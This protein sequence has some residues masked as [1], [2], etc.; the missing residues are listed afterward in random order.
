M[1]TNNSTQLTGTVTTS[2]TNNTITGSGT[3]FTTQM[4]PGTA[5]GI[6]NDS[7]IVV[8]VNSNTSITVG[9]PWSSNNTGANAYSVTAA[10]VTYL[11][12]SLNLFS[13]YKQFQ[14]KIILQ[15]NDSSTVPLVDDLRVLALQM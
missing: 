8:S 9:K 1:S 15:S 11:N 10:G 13:T 12:D 4:L 7:Q 5:I 2:T 14:I 6:A 3:L